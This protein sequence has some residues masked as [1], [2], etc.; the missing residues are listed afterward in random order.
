[1]SYQGLNILA[2]VPARGGSKGIP[3]K[4][5]REVC[6]KSLIGWAAEVVGSL[7]WIDHGIISTD[8]PD[9]A[10][11]A[12]RCGLDAPFLRPQELATDGATA[13]AAWKHAWMEAEGYYN[14]VFD[15]SLYLEPTSP[16]RRPEDVQRTMD[17]L[18]DGEHWAAATV[19]RTPSSFT[20][21]KTLEIDPDG[22]IRFYLADGAG[23]SIR[24]KIPAYYH[25]NGICYAVRRETLLRH[26]YIIEKNCRAVPIERTVVNIDE[27]W[28]L[29]LAEL[30]LAR[31]R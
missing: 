10:A 17:A 24:Q 28:D 3:R 16:C 26:G 4:N 2:V 14:C 7:P 11:E 13:V 6:G 31:A 15:V 25:R 27:P 5:L 19:S 29:E 22:D 1:M 12:M 30:V 18:L 20:P 21:H 23:Y 8:D 9:M